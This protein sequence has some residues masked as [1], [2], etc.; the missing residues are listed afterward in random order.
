MYAEPYFQAF[1]AVVRKNGVEAYLCGGTIRDLLLNRP[2]KDVD[3]VLRDRV[4]ETAQLFSMKIKASYFVLDQERQIVR[5]VCGDGNWDFS[6]F[7]DATIEGDLR[8][9]DFTINA[10][11]VKWE[12]FY[13]DQRLDR[14]ID[15]FSG[16]SDLQQG[17]IRVVDPMSLPDD[18]LRMLRAFR[19]HAELQFEIDPATLAQMEQIN[20]MIAGVAMERITEELDRILLQPDSAKT[21]RR[22]GN[23]TLFDSLFPE[24]KPMKGCE[25]GGYH[26]LDVWLHTV[27][28]LEHF[29]DMLL[30]T[31]DFFPDH[32]EFLNE[33]LNG[34]SGTLD[35]K[36][37]LKWAVLLHD[38][39]K[40]ATR[41]LKEPGR[42]R[43]HGHDHAGAD[44]AETLLNRLKFARKDVQFV[45]KI[46]EHQLRPLNL[47]NQEEQ[48][49]FR[50]F[51]ATGA[52]SIGII[53]VSYGDVSAARG[54]LAVPSRMNEFKDLMNRLFRYYRDEYYPTITMP[55]LVKGRDLMVTF[56][57]KPGPNMGKL[58]KEIREAQ[59][60]G[61]IRSREQALDFA[62][63]RLR[64]AGNI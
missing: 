48:D 25:Q 23:S 63:R 59:L 20:P 54:P 51:R 34:I 24:M 4:L 60:S 40:P 62:S 21:F 37:L 1:D 31:G 61:Q 50:F 22:L 26:H 58:L 41:E 32:H 8:K 11:A 42:W 38:I 27:D 52:E 46:V 33:Y 5:V 47:F 13:P 49:L 12:Q 57:M 14:L 53:L 19:I 36:R 7:R 56:Q 9:R 15:P 35:R 6:I 3:V 17:V 30:R 16:L 43:F 29:E 2:F 18:P 64:D 10:I 44:M 28:A 55:E 45:Q 39:G